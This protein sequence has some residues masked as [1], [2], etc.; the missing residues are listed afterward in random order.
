MLRRRS[1]AKLRHEVEPVD[2]AVLGRFATTW[3]GIVQAAARRR[4]AARRDRAAAG[5]A[6][7]GVDSRDRDPAGADRRLRSG[8]SRRGH[9]GRRSRLGRRRAARRARRPR[10]AVSRRSSAAAAAAAAVR[11][12]PDAPTERRSA[13]PAEPDLSDRETAIL[14][15]LRDRTA[16]RS[17]DRCTRRSAAAIPA[18]TVD[19]LWNLVWQGLV[20]NDTFHALRAFTRARAPRRR[21][22][23]RAA[24]GHGVPIAAARAA[25]GRRTMDAG[26]GS[27]ERDAISPRERDRGAKASRDRTRTTTKWAAAVTQQLLARHGVVT[28]E[29]VAAD[30]V[31]GGF[32][33]VYPVLKGH[34]GDTAASGAATS[35]PASARRSSR[36]PARSICCA[37]CATRP[38]IPRSPCSPPPIRRTRTAR[39]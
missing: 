17:S 1:L 24:D 3:Q 35:S 27:A 15:C 26:A 8:G 36:C 32:G 12:Q 2:Q 19:A 21:M 33:I 9:R 38:T 16:R 39:R 29:A 25:V 4:R 22:K 31:P 14:D 18:E 37:R 13:G 6:A 5:R 20:T 23:G 34:G 28:R 11:L 7:A 10:R 30:G